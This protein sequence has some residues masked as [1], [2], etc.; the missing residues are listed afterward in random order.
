MNGI[1]SK[2]K[3]YNKLHVQ[4][5]RNATSK[6]KGQGKI[7]VKRYTNMHAGT[8]TVSILNYALYST[9]TVYLRLTIVNTTVL[10]TTGNCSYWPIRQTI[11][12]LYFLTNC[13]ILSLFCYSAKYQ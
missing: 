2:H 6:C 13:T 11:L 4:A 7:G 5:M 3:L 12:S 9:G 10:S 8:G 1:D